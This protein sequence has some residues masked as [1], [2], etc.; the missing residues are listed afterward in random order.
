MNTYAH[1][2]YAMVAKYELNTVKEKTSLFS[3]T[4]QAKSHLNKRDRL[5]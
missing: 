4:P 1:F 5:V 2:N 3:T